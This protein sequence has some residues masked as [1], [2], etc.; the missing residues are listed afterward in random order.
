MLSTNFSSR[1]AIISAA[2]RATLEDISILPMIASLG[3]M[4]SAADRLRQ[5]SSAG[6]TW[7]D[8]SQAR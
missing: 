2:D 7:E 6:A 3:A 4:I 5:K 8:L 1:G